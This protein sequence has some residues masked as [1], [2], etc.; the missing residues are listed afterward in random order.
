MTDALTTVTPKP[1]AEVLRG[2]QAK[3][4]KQL[5]DAVTQVDEPLRQE[6]MLHLDSLVNATYALGLE[7]GKQAMKRDI[8]NRLEMME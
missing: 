7:D 8:Q 4:S 2:V 1:K 6:I 5:M 3:I